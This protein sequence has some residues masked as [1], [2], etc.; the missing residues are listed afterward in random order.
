MGKASVVKTSSN[1]E[2]QYKHD[3]TMPS[4]A[5]TLNVEDGNA[6]FHCMKEMPAPLKQTCEKIHDISIMGKSNLLFGTDMY[7]KI[8]SRV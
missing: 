6:I 2:V 4:N 5:K 3:F 8:L 7:K 1:R